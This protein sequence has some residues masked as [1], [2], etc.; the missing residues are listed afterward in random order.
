MKSARDPVFG[1]NRVHADFSVTATACVRS[2][3]DRGFDAADRIAN[4]LIVQPGKAHPYATPSVFL[5]GETSAWK[6]R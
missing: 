2:N 5:S 4:A 6:K 3:A 1:W